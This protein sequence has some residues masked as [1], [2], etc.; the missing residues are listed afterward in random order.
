M[1]DWKNLDTL[2][3]FKKL[4][5]MKGKVDIKNALDGSEAAERV[6]A[7]VC[8]MAA[9]LSYSYAAKQVDDEVLEALEALAK[10]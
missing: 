2:E 3:S 4:Q 6:K 10:E 1:A 8:P 5:S 9:G 7:Y